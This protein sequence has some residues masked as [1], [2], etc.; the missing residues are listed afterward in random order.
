MWLYIFAVVLLVIGVVGSI[1]SGG[2]FTIV[3]VPL[4]VIA[5]ITAG[6][7]TLW[8]RAQQGQAGHTGDSA[9]SRDRPLP[10][11]HSNAAT[12][13]STP[14]DLVNARREAQ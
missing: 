7:A 14:S 2:I 1:F 11:G 5:L 6:V 4:G 10:T 12:A 8:I 13:P 3:I 9:E